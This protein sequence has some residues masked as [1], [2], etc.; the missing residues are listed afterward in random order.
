LFWIEVRIA[1]G[2]CFVKSNARHCCSNVVL[3]EKLQLVERVPQALL[4]KQSSNMHDGF[5]QKKIEQLD[6]EIQCYQVKKK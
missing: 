6:T 2:A 3:S 5:L 1:S 4:L